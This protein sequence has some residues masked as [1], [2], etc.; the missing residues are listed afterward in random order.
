MHH[1]GAA[2]ASRTR[3]AIDMGGTEPGGG[4]RAV[5]A[6]APGSARVIVW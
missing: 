2:P 1:D 5:F 4:S 6:C 3:S